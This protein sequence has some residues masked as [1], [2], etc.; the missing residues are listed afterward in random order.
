MEEGCDALT[1]H[2]GVLAAL[3]SRP[4]WRLE[5]RGQVEAEAGPETVMQP[6]FNLFVCM[7]RLFVPFL[8]FYFYQSIHPQGER[9][10]RTLKLEQCLSCL[11]LP[12]L[13]HLVVTSWKVS[14][15]IPPT[16]LRLHNSLMLFSLHL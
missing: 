8:F 11:T 7:P 16:A 3:K 6:A 1:S 5:N 9:E 2:S 13:F 4:P 15:F 12:P 14:G 10:K